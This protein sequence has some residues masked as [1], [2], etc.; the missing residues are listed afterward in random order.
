MSAGS[1]S[2]L[3][4][5]GT[6][7]AAYHSTRCTF[8]FAGTY[9]HECGAP[10]TLAAPRSSGITKSGVYWSR[11]CPECSKVKGGENAGLGAFE[12]FNPERHR[13]EFR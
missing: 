11:R 8:A 10:A 4:M 12:V 13:N 6:E 2:L 7:L 9:G 3:D 5:S 1:A